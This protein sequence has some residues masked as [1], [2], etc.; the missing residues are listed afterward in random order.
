MLHLSFPRKQ[1]LPESVVLVP[2]LRITSEHQKYPGSAFPMLIRG[3]RRPWLCFSGYLTCSSWVLNSIFHPDLC[4]Q[5]E[6]FYT[7]GWRREL[8]WLVQVWQERAAASR[9]QKG[10]PWKRGYGQQLIPSL[11]M[12]NRAMMTCASPICQKHTQGAKLGTRCL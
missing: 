12:A 5:L 8:R 9:P 4:F 10:E 2:V 3:Q 1:K 11:P 6:P 7:C